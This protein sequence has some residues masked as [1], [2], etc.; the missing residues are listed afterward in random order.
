MKKVCFS[1]LAL[2]LV[3]S[4]IGCSKKEVSTSKNVPSK[5]GQSTMAAQETE[6]AIIEEF[7]RS[8]SEAVFDPQPVDGW[9]V[10][11]NTSDGSWEQVEGT[12][13]EI[14]ADTFARG[15]PELTFE[16]EKDNIS[17]LEYSV[18]GSRLVMK[19]TYKPDDYEYHWEIH[20]EKTDKPVNISGLE[21]HLLM[22]DGERDNGLQYAYYITK[23]YM[24]FEL[25]YAEK[26]GISYSLYCDNPQTI[27]GEMCAAPE[28]NIIYGFNSNQP[29]YPAEL[30]DVTEK[31]FY[32]PI[33]TPVLVDFNIKT[34]DEIKTYKYRLGSSFEAWMN[35]ELNTDGWYFDNNT[36]NYISA[37]GKYSINSDFCPT[38]Y[39]QP[40]SGLA[41]GKSTT[42][43]LYCFNS[44]TELYLT[45][46]QVL[47]EQF[48]EENVDGIL[49]NNIRN[50]LGLTDNITIN[51][52]VY[53]DGIVE[54]MKVYFAP[55]SGNT[56][57]LPADATEVPVSET[58]VTRQQPYG[59]EEVLAATV[60]YKP[61]EDPNFS[62]NFDVDMFIAYKD[63]IIY[64]VVFPQFTR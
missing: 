31:G 2:S 15:F 43:A 9:A 4:I 56:T 18:Q 5:S 21:P 57:D 7:A 34:G 26:T 44:K 23:D 36:F 48:P 29:A 33:K 59:D 41:P 55:H 37:D 13:Q 62:P 30:Y 38:I 51:M 32:H 19:L 64:K 1:I 52:D 50:Y 40:Y 22:W 12:T 11:Q 3:V 39:A 45:G 47:S 58:T 20:A 14:T 27:D 60:N 24:D 10:A 54:N 6:E 49:L 28:P 61:A 25:L 17:N 53:Y 16:F 46:I 35:S 8:V 63:E 42:K